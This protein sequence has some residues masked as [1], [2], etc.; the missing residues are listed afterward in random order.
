MV[1][2]IVRKWNIRI[3]ECETERDEIKSIEMKLIWS[4]RERENQK[5]NLK[6][7]HSEKAW[8]QIQIE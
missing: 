5:E 4:D 7:R 1:V 8:A 3:V 2:V 6:Q